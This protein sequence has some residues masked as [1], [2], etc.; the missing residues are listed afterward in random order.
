MP[1]FK[2][3]I[4]RGTVTAPAMIVHAENQAKAE[5][6]ARD[7]SGLGRFKTWLFIPMLMNE[8][9][10]TRRTRKYI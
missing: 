6:I 7:S 10:V 1:K 4:K 9:V 3:L 2:M 8:R 5:K